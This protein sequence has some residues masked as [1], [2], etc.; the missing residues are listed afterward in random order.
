MRLRLPS[1]GLDRPTLVIAGVVSL[2]LVMS[3]LDTTIVNVALDRLAQDLDTPLSTVQWV[4]TGYL[5]ALAVVIPLSGWATERFGSRRVWLVSVALFGLGSALCGLSASIGQ[6]I[7]FRILQGLGSGMLMPVG[8]TVLAQAAGPRRAGTALAVLGVPILLGPICGPIVGGLI[9][10]DVSWHWI[11]FVNVPIAAVAFALAARVLSPEAGR[12]D[13]GRL[14]WRGAAL[15]CPGLVGVVFGL[16]ETQAHGGLGAPSAFAPIAAGLLLIAAFCGHARRSSAPLI[17]LSLFRRPAF[18]AAAASTFLVAICLFGG[19]LLIPLYFQLDRGQSA[20]SAGL[21]IAPQGVGSAVALPLCGRLTDRI[22]GGPVVLFGTIVATA[23][24]VPWAFATDA[25][26]LWLL[27]V[28]QF[29]RGLGLGASVQPAAAAALSVLSTESV[30]DG[31]ATLNTIRQIGASIGTALSAVLLEGQAR[32]VAGH[33]S[34]SGVLRPLPDHVRA[35][36]AGPLADAFDT[37]FAWIA[38]LS[39][40]S[41]AGAAVLWLTEARAARPATDAGAARRAPSP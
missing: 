40:V 28:L 12:G 27:V 11:F 37:A 3:L 18:A 15:I 7:A 14:D 4:A 20:L 26:P 34:G 25:T 22:G 16:S 23:L 6:L 29:A 2:G 31:T 36:V 21:L 41:I 39:A 19:L 30:P 17:D 24:T 1:L 38:V 13:A 5:L 9:V 8:F 33:G 32:E 10:D 35:A